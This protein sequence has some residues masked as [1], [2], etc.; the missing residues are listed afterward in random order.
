ME[1]RIEQ[2]VNKTL[3]CMGGDFGIQVSPVFT[4]NLNRRMSDVRIS[5]GAGF[6]SRSFYPVMI[7]VV[8]V[9]NLAIGLTTFTGNKYNEGD[10]DNQ[11]SSLASEYGIG[12]NRYSSF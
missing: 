9:L 4:E 8:L 2:E 10:A 5:R 1:N 11:L 12:S 7:S 3:E 6:R